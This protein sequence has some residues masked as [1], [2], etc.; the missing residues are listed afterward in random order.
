MSTVATILTAIGYRFAG[1]KTIT[2]STD[3]SQ[4]TVIQ[5]LN[6]TALWLTGFCAENKSS[7]GKTTGTITAIAAIITAATKA[8]PCV[9]TAAS[10]GLVTGD[11]I[12]IKV[13]Q[14]MTEL[15]DT[16][17][18]ATKIT[19]DTFSIGVDSSAYT[20]YVSG[21]YASKASYNTI[22]A[23]LYA[24]EEY[25]WIVESHN[26]NR[27]ELTTEDIVLGRDPVA[28]NEPEMFYVDGSNNIVL[29]DSPDA[30]YT[31]KIPYWQL[32]TAMTGTDSTVPFLGLFDNIFTEAAVL[33][34]QNRDEYDLS[35]E[36]KWQSFLNDRARRVIEL[37]KGLTVNIGL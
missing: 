14:G 19:N 21:G 12:V 16:T 10:H 6:E 27:I 23:T 35:F 18:T 30:V 24:T 13:V 2:S 8:S 31:I 29:V 33:R 36:L 3:P 4:A 9:I 17:H 26:R 22:A 32:P 34:S 37:R 7:L 5:W 28:T 25:G 11:S 1:G 15:N 20:T